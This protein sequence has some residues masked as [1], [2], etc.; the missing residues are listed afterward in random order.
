MG[1]AILIAVTVVTFVVWRRSRFFGTAAPLL[2]SLL[3]FSLGIRMQFSAFLFWFVALPF[4]MLFM[5]GV[6]TDLLESRYALAA[7][8]V[9]FGVLIANAM[10]DIYGLLNLSPRTR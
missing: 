6:S 7:N 10:I 1:L 4:L 2:I 3:L 8:A 9:V 5:A